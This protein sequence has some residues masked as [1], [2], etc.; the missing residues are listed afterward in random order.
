M[1]DPDRIDRVLTK[2][3]AIWKQSPDLRLGQILE[4]VK[5]EADSRYVIKNSAFNVED[6]VIEAGLDV[7]IS[8]RPV[9]TAPVCLRCLDSRRM[10]LGGYS[11]LCTRCP[12]PCD[13]C[14]N[15]GGFCIVTHCGCTCHERKS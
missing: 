1:R 14:N 10:W 13:R 5:R 12:T 3:G 15:G 6:D 9:P 2:L 8:K 11:V 7:W 4:C